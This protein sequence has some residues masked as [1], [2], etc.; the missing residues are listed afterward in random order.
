MSIDEELFVIWSIQHQL[1]WAPGEAGYCGLVRD[2]GTY[3]RG[4]AERIVRAANLVKFH[5]CMIP[6]AAVRR[7]RPSTTVDR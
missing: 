2:A 1:W 7:Q 3:T 4:H 5:E 6:L